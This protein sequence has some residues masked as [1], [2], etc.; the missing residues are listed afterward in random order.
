[1]SNDAGLLSLGGYAYQ[2][3]V[4]IS[5]LPKLN[6]NS[7]LCFEKID[8]ISINEKNIDKSN[9]LS[10]IISDATECSYTAIQVKKT[11]IN[12]TAQKKII[13][14]WL[15]IMKQFANI[16]K[17]VLYFDSTLNPNLSCFTINA[18]SLLQYINTS[19]KDNPNSLVQKVKKIYAN[20][21]DLEKDFD[22][23]IQNC[24]FEAVNSI[25]SV[26][27]KR[28]NALF[29][30]ND[31]MG[32]VYSLRIEELCSKI[33][34]EIISTVEAKSSYCISQSE[35]HSMIEGICHRVTE[36]E[37]KPDYAEFTKSFVFDQSKI[38]SSRE[39][40][41]LVKCNLRTQ[42]IK[43]YLSNQMYYNDY[44]YRLLCIR[45]ASK[46]DA[47]EITAYENFE[48]AVD[49]LIDAGNDSP[50][51]R[52][53]ETIKKPNSYAVDNQICTGAYIHLTEEGIEKEKQ[54]SWSDESE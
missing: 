24:S 32:S 22:Y 54:I 20:A 21:Q 12:S 41:Q 30:Y 25:E 14:N 10:T 7:Q 52:L 15:I 5:L 47:L 50:S 43:K 19:K 13:L 33:Q 11:A 44:R 42:S 31:T 45:K 6:E 26:I 40:G 9:S 18:K 2:I 39:Y 51:S 16:R 46:I 1:M 36:E 38:S 29:H 8:D 53:H 23:I 49:Y 4:F 28:Y 27:F 3:K 35:F 37:Y 17:F 48:S 34:H